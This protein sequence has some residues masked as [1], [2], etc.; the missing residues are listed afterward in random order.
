LEIVGAKLTGMPQFVEIPAPVMTTTFL[1]FDRASA[2]SCSCSSQAEETFVVGIALF[3]CHM[4]TI[5]GI[6]QLTRL[7]KSSE[8]FCP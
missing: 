5:R 2:I 4:Q 7:G 8:Q 3:P 1:D 6:F